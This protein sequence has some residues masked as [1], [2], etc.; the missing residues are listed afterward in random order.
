M[1]ARND[2]QT[3][4]EALM[5]Q[6]TINDELKFTLM[7]REKRRDLEILKT[8]QIYIN[9]NSTSKEIEEW[10]R[11]KGFSD[12]IV[13]KLHGLNGDEL[14]DLSAHVLEGYFGQKESRRLI[15]QIVLQKNIC[16]VIKLYF[17]NKQVHN[18]NSKIKF[19]L[20][21]SFTLS[22]TKQFVR[23]NCLPN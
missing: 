23:Q 2:C 8:P 12:L 4:D 15:S 1:R 14:F 17:G 6:S 22:S 9:Q 18:F 16:E 5:L 20:F 11:G 3:D 7:Q 10:L 19:I 13:K 21:S